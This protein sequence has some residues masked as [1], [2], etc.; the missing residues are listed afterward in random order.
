MFPIVKSTCISGDEFSE[1]LLME[2]KVCIPAGIEFGQSGY[3]HIRISYAYA[4]DQ[5]EKGA[6]RMAE[7][8]KELKANKK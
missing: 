2:K 3:D 6:E 8:V 7:M 5:I 4:M 1:R